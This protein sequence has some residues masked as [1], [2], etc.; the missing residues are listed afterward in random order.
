MNLKFETTTIYGITIRHGDMFDVCYYN[1]LFL[2][3]F[4]M[5]IIITLSYEVFL[6]SKYLEIA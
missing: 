3:I 4:W 5:Q 2:I 1:I 6:F